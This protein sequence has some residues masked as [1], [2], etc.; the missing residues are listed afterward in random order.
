MPAPK[1]KKSKSSKANAPAKADDKKE[2]IKSVV[3]KGKSPVDDACPI[4]NKVVVYYRLYYKFISTTGQTEKCASRP[5]RE[6]N[7]RPLDASPMLCQLSYAV[8]SVE[9]EIFQN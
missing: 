2:A 4:K 1:T 7:L 3:F 5:R 9:Y 6:P 8:G